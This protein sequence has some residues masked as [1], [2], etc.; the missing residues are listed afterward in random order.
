[1]TRGDPAS[2][3][4]IERGWKVA[5]A[6]GEELGTV[7]E[8]LGDRNADIFDGLAVKT[9]RLGTARYVAA[10]RVTAIETGHV[11]LDIPL[12]DAEHLPAYERPAPQEAILSESSSL[13]DRLAG[14]FRGR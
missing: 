7:A 9:S 1:V 11:S 5:A 12:A 14:W 4:V 13:W 6:G 10:E 3:L 2:W 8:V